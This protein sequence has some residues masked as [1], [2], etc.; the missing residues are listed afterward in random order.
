MTINHYNKSNS[1]INTPQIKSYKAPRSWGDPNH[2]L[3][4]LKD[5]WYKTIIKLEDSISIGIFEFFHEIG[6]KTMHMPITTNSISSPMG[7][8][9]DSSPV[10]VELFGIETFLSDSM[11]FMLEYGVRMTETGGY[12]LMPSFRGEDA[13]QRHLCQ[14]YHAEA[15]IHTGGL[16]QV[17]QLVEKCLLTMTQKI[18]NICG[19]EIIRIAGSVKHVESMLEHKS[20]FPRVTFEEALALLGGNNH[21]FSEIMPNC[22]RIT[23]KG[24]SELIQRFGGFVWLTHFD[25][26]AVPFYQAFADDSSKALAADLL[27][28]IGETVG[29]GERH[30]TE[31]QVRRAFAT[32]RVDSTEY[33]WYC[34]MK[35]QFPLQT[36]GFGLGTER[37]ICWLL[38][39]N[40]VRDCQLFPRFNRMANVP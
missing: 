5:P 26:L 34:E 31:A 39:H 37:Y 10:K 21:F 27:F 38:Q 36:A 14:F 25:H 30:S 8:G 1:Q 29:A 11:Q 6:F 3:L 22:R 2:Y 13:D 15:E 18:L 32:H 20:G 9:S 16:E 19:D 4:A 35:K 40:D 33:A 12:Y 28:G 7:V 24:E 17:I 23:P